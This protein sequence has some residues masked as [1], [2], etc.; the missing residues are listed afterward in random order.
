MEAWDLKYKENLD[1]NHAW[2]A[3]PANII[4]RYLMGVRPLEPGFS[5][6]LIQPQP[7][8]LEHASATVPTIRGAVK[9]AFKNH[10]AQPFELNIE[11]PVNMTARVG[12]PQKNKQSTSLVVDGKKVDAQYQDGYL[13]VDGI[14]SGTHTLI[15]R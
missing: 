3:A 5:T 8:N 9:V 4:P 14:G 15:S 2:G 7:G 13:F 1:W 11:L 12:L 6:V 10:P